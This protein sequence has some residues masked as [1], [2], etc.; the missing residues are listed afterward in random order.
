[1]AIG[2]SNRE[3]KWRTNAWESLMSPRPPSV[4]GSSTQ[5]PVIEDWA[6]FSVASGPD[7]LCCEFLADCLQS[8][9]GGLEGEGVQLVSFMRRPLAN[10]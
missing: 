5:V 10:A 6:R 4:A 2:G 1:M 8:E 3:L 7:F 9:M